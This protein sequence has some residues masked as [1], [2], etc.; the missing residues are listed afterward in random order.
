M[1]N[2]LLRNNYIMNVKTDTIESC[3]NVHEAIIVVNN[4]LRRVEQLTVFIKFNNKA[5]WLKD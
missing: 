2:D 5:K 3:A 4:L 1:N